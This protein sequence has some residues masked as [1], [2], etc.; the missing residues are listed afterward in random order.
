M[1]KERRQSLFSRSEEETERIARELAVDL[2]PGT[3]ITL[4]G[5]LGSGKTVFAGA[6]AEGC[7]V[8]RPQVQSP[9]YVILRQ[10]TTGNILIYHWDL[11]RIASVDELETADFPELLRDRSALTI[12]EWARLFPSLWEQH[13]PRIEITLSEGENHAE[14]WIGLRFID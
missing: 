2:L 8:P 6:I 4:D 9:T 1:L 7:G 12:I 3:L 13:M 10:Y 11:Y 14:R 5:P